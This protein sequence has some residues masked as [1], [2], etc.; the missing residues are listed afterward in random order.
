MSYCRIGEDSDVYLIRSGDMLVCYCA[1]EGNEQET[2]EGMISHLV[3]HQERGHKVPQRAIAR[4]NAERLGIPY[5][6][7]V[8]LALEEFR[9]IPPVEWPTRWGT[10]DRDTP[11]KNAG[12]TEPNGPV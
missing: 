6:T 8:E 4:L 5:K 2:E 12:L 10:T 1:L 11:G 3:D 9:T 7:D